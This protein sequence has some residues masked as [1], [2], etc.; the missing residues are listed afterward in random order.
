MVEAQCCWHR[1][2]WV[3]ANPALTIAALS[4]GA[5]PSVKVTIGG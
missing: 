4:L 2:P 3:P 5:V 1:S